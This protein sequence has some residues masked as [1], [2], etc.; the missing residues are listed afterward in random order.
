MLVPRQKGFIAA[1]NALRGSH[2][3]HVYGI[4][5]SEKTSL[6]VD[7]TVAYHP[8][9]LLPPTMLQIFSLSRISPFYKFHVHVRRYDITD[10]E[11]D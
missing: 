8:T 1:I 10:V 7:F 6:T 9:D 11:P 5:F 4:S 2:V 3:R